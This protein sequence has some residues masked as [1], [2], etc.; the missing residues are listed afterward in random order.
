[1]RSTLSIIILNCFFVLIPPCV[2]AKDIPTD[3]NL[4]IIGWSRNERYWAFSESGEYSGGALGG[5]TRRFF[6]VNSDKNIFYKTFEKRITEDEGYDTDLKVQQEDA[7]YS[8]GIMD[9]INRLGSP[10]K[11]GT[12]VYKKPLAIWVDV[13]SN[14]KQFGEKEVRFKEKG[15]EH[16]IKLDETTDNAEDKYDVKSKFSVSMKSCRI[17]QRTLQSDKSL[18][19]DFLQYRIVY[20]ALSPSGTKIVVVVEAIGLGFE[21]A[22]IPYYKAITG[23]M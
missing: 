6:V 15:C 3:S 4:S 21:G 11:L 13:D 19:R 2:T 14:V 23:S 8:K 12:E 17:N 18:S 7:L 20:I 16:I 22:R 9:I 1:M 5:I 10:Y